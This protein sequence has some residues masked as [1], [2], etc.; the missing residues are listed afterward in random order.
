[1]LHDGMYPRSRRSHDRDA[2]M[3]GL[4]ISVD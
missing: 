4:V 3:S 2:S 1:L